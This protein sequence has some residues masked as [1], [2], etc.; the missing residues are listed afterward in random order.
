MFKVESTDWYSQDIETIWLAYTD[1]ARWSEWTSI[2][3]SSLFKEGS[4]DKNGVGAVRKLGPGG[5]FSA[6]E[7][8]LAFEPQKRLEYTVYKGP[9]PFINH[10]GIV[11]FSE[12]NGGTR[13][14]WQCTYEAKLRFIGKLMQKITQSVFDS[15]LKG[16]HG[17]PFDSIKK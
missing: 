6:Y 12:E 11:N 1:H 2:P 14:E 15:A 13:I 7:E 10:R 5:P 9:L 17:F 16:L 3:K 8:I 4:E